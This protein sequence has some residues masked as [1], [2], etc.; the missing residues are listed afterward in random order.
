MKLVV[1]CV[2]RAQDSSPTDTSGTAP[3]EGETVDLR[4]HWKRPYSYGY[5][6]N[7]YG[8]SSYPSNY[9][10]NYGNYYQQQQ[11]YQPFYPSYGYSNYYSGSSYQYSGG[12]YY[13]LG[14]REGD[15][16]KETSTPASSST[17]DQVQ[18]S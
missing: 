12:S 6:N 10:N 14:Y 5:G 11:H 17:G 18:F 8:Y 1:V 3:G 16:N 13:G 4:H 15:K 9:Y 2:A 7:Y